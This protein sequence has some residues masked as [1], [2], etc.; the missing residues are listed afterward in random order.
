M[1]QDVEQFIKQEKWNI[2]LGDAI[3]DFGRNRQ[4]RGRGPTHHLPVA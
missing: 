1:Y 3:R 2:A 4:D